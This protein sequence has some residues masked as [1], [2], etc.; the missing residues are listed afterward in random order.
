MRVANVVGTY[1]AYPVIFPID[2]GRVVL[3]HTR[4]GGR[5]AYMDTHLYC[6][7]VLEFS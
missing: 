7:K 5:A 1:E 3:I 2:L 4:M 6:T